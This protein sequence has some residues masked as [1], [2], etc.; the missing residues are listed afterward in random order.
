M[1]RSA[2]SGRRV[3]PPPWPV[4]APCRPLPVDAGRALRR[5]LGPSEGRTAPLVPPSPATRKR[6][7]RSIACLPVNLSVVRLPSAGGPCAP[8]RP[9]ARTT[10]SGFPAIA[11]AL[12]PHVA[13]GRGGSPVVKLSASAAGSL[14]GE[15]GSTG[16]AG[17]PSK[18][19]V[20]GGH[21]TELEVG[22]AW[23]ACHCAELVVEGDVI[24]G[25]RYTFRR[26]GPGLAART[27]GSRFR[28]TRRSM[29]TPPRRPRS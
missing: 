15:A 29:C 13:D 4:A 9:A 16:E 21:Y 2:H 12:Q 6:V 3:F 18:R 7:R 11:Q 27:G 20:L 26:A 28:P 19:H 17:H 23:R 22:V 25:A 14:T 8:S 5:V 24:R 10:M 1:R